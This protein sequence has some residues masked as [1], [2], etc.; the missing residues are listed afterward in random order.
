M[1]VEKVV[2]RAEAKSM[3]KCESRDGRLQWSN[4]AEHVRLIFFSFHWLKC[5]A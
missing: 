4:Q 1:V 5:R 3:A 2:D